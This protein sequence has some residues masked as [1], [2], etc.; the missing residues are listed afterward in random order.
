MHFEK[1]LQEREE[2]RH[3]NL[4][5]ISV[6][7]SVQLLMRSNAVLQRLALATQSKKAARIPTLKSF[8]CCL[9]FLFLHV[10]KG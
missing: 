3:L 10:E 7:C 8:I 4:N 1:R 6:V 5:G 9:F 2:N